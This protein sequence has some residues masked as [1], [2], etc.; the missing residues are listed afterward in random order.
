MSWCGWTTIIIIIIIIINND[1]IYIYNEYIE[2]NHHH[3]HHHY[4]YIK[5]DDAWHPSLTLKSGW[6]PDTDTRSQDEAAAVCDTLAKTWEFFGGLELGHTPLVAI[7]DQLVGHFRRNND[8]SGS[9][10][11]MFRAG[12]WN[13]EQIDMNLSTIFAGLHNMAI[14]LDIYVYLCHIILHSWWFRTCFFR[15][16]WDNPSHWLIFFKMVKTTNQLCTII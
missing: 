1:S 12:S 9:I 6:P 2:N 4:C 7:L 14:A 10:W 13:G 16:I 8:D 15:N 3:H 5:V 11:D